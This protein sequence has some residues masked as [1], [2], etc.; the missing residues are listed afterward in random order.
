MNDS[1][2]CTA[3]TGIK[4]AHPARITIGTLTYYLASEIKTA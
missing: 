3:S 1:T 2:S 4:W